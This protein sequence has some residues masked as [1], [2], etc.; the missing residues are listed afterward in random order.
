MIKKIAVGMIALS[1][2]TLTLVGCGSSSKGDVG[3]TDKDQ[4]TETVD[5]E[6]TGDFI[7][8]GTNAEFMPFEYRDGK[9]VVGFDVD[10]ANKI[11]EKLGKELKIVDMKFAGLIAALESG[12][13]DFIAAGMSK[14]PE[15]EEQ[16]NFSDSYYTASQLITVKAD[17]T[18]IT[19]GDDLK[20]KKI[21]VQLGTT[22]EE[23]AKEIE[24]TTVVSYD[25][26]AM[27]IIDLANGKVDAVVL[28][29]EPTKNYTMDNDDV[30]V[31][32]EE[33]TQEEYSIA[34]SKDN[35]E[36]LDV[37][38]ETLKELK[39]SGEYQEIVNKYF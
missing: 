39:E 38:N 22:G 34:I 2:A 10:I 33:L 17:N 18:D 16:V 9:E 24:G 14:T 21:G 11:A 31:L 37:I 32:D 19:S 23:L 3:S 15:R 30:K 25:K 13:I 4:V 36:L 1:I 29:S 6:S 20:G 8:M 27:A 5:K 26:G 7:I 12:K 28:D 35:Q